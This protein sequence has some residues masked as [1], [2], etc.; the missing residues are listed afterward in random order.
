MNQ[1]KDFDL[2]KGKCKYLNRWRLGALKK[3]DNS[4]IDILEKPCCERDNLGAWGE[5]SV[6]YLYLV[7]K[8]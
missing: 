2:W 1:R 4:S 5:D 8:L 6:E 3:E 7:G